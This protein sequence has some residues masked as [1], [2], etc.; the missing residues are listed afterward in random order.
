MAE[1]LLKTFALA[2]G[3][4]TAT[5]L[6]GGFRRIDIKVNEFQVFGPESQG[7]RKMK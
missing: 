3:P 5:D 1:S 6:R 2:P 7:Q 4:Q